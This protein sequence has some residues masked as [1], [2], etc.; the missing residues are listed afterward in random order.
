MVL[1][2][3]HT[4]KLNTNTALPQITPTDAP[5]LFW[6]NPMAHSC[7]FTGQPHKWRSTWNPHS[8]RMQS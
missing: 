2:P 4:T 1:R 6:Q 8:I 3:L 5:Q 7:P